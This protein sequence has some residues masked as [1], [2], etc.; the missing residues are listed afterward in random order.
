M[1]R[2][3]DAWL[4]YF[5][6]LVLVGCIAEIARGEGPVARQAAFADAARPVPTPERKPLAP[7]AMLA[8][9]FRDPAQ[10]REGYGL[11]LDL[12]P[13]LRVFAAFL[14]D[15]GVTAVE[16]R[17]K[18]SDDPVAV[19]ASFDVAQNLPALRVQIGDKSPEPFGAFYS[20]NKGIRW[21]L[22]W[23][24][25]RFS[26]R[27]EGGQDSEFGYF[28]IAGMQWVDPKRPIA[29]GFGVPMNL[30]NARGGVGI[31]AQ[32]RMRLF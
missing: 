26:L 23:P 2:R 21:A 31:I 1:V 14:R 18:K 13:V 4:A 15:H 6:T 28:G 29:F 3:N 11:N 5:G 17:A 9:G 10:F 8:E 19:S 24:V 22:I 20:G 32:F 16:H 27:I 30:R 25:S 7:D 12:S